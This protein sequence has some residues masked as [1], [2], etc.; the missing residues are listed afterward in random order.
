M[1]RLLADTTPLRE[2]AD[3]RR[4]FAGQLVSF[5]G[6]QLTTV[7]VA[8]QVYTITGS[9]L[10][11][12]LVSLAQL[13]P[14]IIGS[15]IGGSIADSRD[16]RTLIRNMQVALAATS[17]A[18]ALNA[19]AD[20]PAL[21]PLFVFSSLAAGL[22]GVDRPAR[23]AAIPNLVRRES[24]P[25]AYAL[26]QIL[27]QIGGVAGPA[28]AGILLDRTS[29]ATVYWVDVVTYA[30]A[31]LAA[32]RMR[33]L[34][35][36]GG[37]TRAGFGSIAEGFRYLRSNRLLQST[38]VIDLD[39]MVFGLPR[40]LF[41]QLGLDVFGGGTT[42]VG[43]LYA[44][45][46]A[47]AL[48]GALFTGWVSRIRRQGMAVLVSVGVWGLAIIGFGITSW[49]PLALVL[50]AIA[51]GADVISAVF[52]NTILQ[53]AVPDAL[54]GR[55]SAVH[56]AVVTGGPRVGDLEA[57]AVEAISSARTSVISGGVACVLGI[58]A[59]ARWWPE[60]RAYDDRVAVPAG[61]PR[62]TPDPAAAPLPE[63][64]PTAPD[65]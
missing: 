23:S 63:P 58:F 33:P 14:L 15:V 47:G 20:R 59:V 1:P 46:G 9:S 31:F 37:G 42:T 60:L 28:V 4:L 25:A 22:S 48:A 26:W 39:A 3:F 11:V 41:P 13:G 64:P 55:I 61:E 40:A 18:L 53:M 10:A 19:M 45:P 57:G 27:L 44:A 62:S 12:G 6:T 36:E 8:V 24:L 17:A 29:I 49:L 43:L 7:A 5:L 2:S 52:R 21:W 34:P 35:P 56:I 50:L 51:G 54:R 32:A 38:F 16:R 65:P 30:A